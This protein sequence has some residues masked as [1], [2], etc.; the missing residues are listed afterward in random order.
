M[1]G[2]ASELGLAHSSWKNAHGLTEKEKS[3]YSEGY[4]SSFRRTSKRLSIDQ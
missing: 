2:Y 3:L 1:N 4:C